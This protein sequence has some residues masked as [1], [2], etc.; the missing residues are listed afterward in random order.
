LQ[1]ADGA[2]GAGLGFDG[3]GKGRRFEA[4][5]ISRSQ[6]FIYAAD[7]ASNYTYAMGAAKLA[8]VLKSA[9]FGSLSKVWADSAEKAWAWAER[10][11]P[12]GSANGAIRD[13]YF[14][15]ELNLKA[16]AGW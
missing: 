15:G 13:A 6:A 14:I 10:F 2:V 16:N 5:S 1:R 3:G 12:S 9:G 8:I 7:P 11:Y 4:S